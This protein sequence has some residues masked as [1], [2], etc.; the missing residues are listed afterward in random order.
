MKTS[1]QFISLLF[2]AIYIALFTPSI[3]FVAK[4]QEALDFA[5]KMS[6]LAKDFTPKTGKFGKALSDL[7]LAATIF[8]FADSA[9]QL[10]TTNSS[11]S[12]EQLQHVQVCNI[13]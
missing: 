6:T 11:R 8:G 10:F 2:F 7:S 4:R 3:A 13:P 5:Q 12:P 9:F 1:E